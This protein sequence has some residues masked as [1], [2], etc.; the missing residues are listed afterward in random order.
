MNQHA[1]DKCCMCRGSLLTPMPPQTRLQS[2]KAAVRANLQETC[3]ASV[4]VEELIQEVP[5][6]LEIMTPQ[7][8]KQLAATSAGLHKQIHGYVTSIAL[9]HGRINEE[10]H[11][12]ALVRGRRPMLRVLDLSNSNLNNDGV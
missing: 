1:K 5:R 10:S 9:P 2:K 12:R 6:V 8:L 4:T 7:M 3:R 11:M